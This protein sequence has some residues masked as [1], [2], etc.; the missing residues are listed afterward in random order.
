FSNTYGP[1]LIST[2]Q[3]KVD[4]SFSGASLMCFSYN[5]SGAAD[6]NNVTDAL[7]ARSPTLDVVAYA[8]AGLVC[9]TIVGCAIFTIMTKP[10]KPKGSSSSDPDAGSAGADNGARDERSYEEQTSAT[11]DDEEEDEDDDE[12]DTDE[13]SERTTIRE[14]RTTLNKVEDEVNNDKDDN[15]DADD[16]QNDEDPCEDIIGNKWCPVWDRHW[17]SPSTTLD[18]LLKLLLLPF[19]NAHELGV[20]VGGRGHSSKRGRPEICRALSVLGSNPSPVPWPAGGPES[21]RSPCCRL[22]IYKNINQLIS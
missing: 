18:N 12:A 1:K 4:K 9:M 5:A 15:H 6:H 7:R 17:R 21:L 20:G 8:V 16:D 19:L 2:F 22:A 10:K 13:E 14:Q 3:A 11:S